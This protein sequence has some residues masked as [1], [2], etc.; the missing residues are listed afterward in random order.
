MKWYRRSC[1][2][3][4]S[5]G[6]LRIFAGL[7]CSSFLSTAL[8]AHT[9]ASANHLHQ[10]SAS[11]AGR[12]GGLD[13]SGKARRG[14][15]S[16]YSRSFYRKKM[17][18]GTKMN[19][20][21]NAAASKTLPLGTSARV[22]NLENGNSDVV[23]I[24]DRGPHVKDRIVDVSPKTADNLGMKKDGTALV[25]VKPIDVPQLDGSVKRGAGAR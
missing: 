6:W 8:A 17:S 23:Q 15:A 20:Q 13:R 24:R 4:R 1:L 16:Y 19:P 3:C 12:D 2:H 5:R 7:I 21:S 9:N 11:K 22:T 25:E 18:D 14:K 10:H